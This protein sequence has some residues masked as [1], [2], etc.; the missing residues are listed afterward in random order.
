[1]IDLM[2]LPAHEAER[3]AHVEGFKGTAELFARIA[4]LQRALGQ[5]T[6]DIE[7]LQHEL[8]ILKRER[9]YGDYA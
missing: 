7:G 8:Y 3:L 1:M 5:A 2:K 4:D 6:A 9:A